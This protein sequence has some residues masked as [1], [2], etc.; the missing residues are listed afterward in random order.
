M[1]NESDDR[2]LRLEGSPTEVGAAF[3]AANAE[4]I[5]AEVEGFIGGG[6]D[7]LLRATALYREILGRIA[8]HWLEEAAA[9][10]GAAG[11]GAEDLT[12]CMGAK[13][14]GINRPECFTYFSAPRHN[15][16]GITLFHK[17]RDN[18]DRPQAAYVKALRAGGRMI[19]RC[20]ATET[21]RTRAR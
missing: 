7:S 10:A 19:L 15:R 9:M 4:D 16:D 6:R 18:R 12:A 13:Y 8:P 20:A 11:V 5:R 2:L 14:R 21:R 3:G 1:E 17:N